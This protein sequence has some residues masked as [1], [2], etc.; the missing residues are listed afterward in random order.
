MAALVRRSG[1]RRTTTG[2]WYKTHQ[3]SATPNYG[4]AIKIPLPLLP[5]AARLN[6][7]GS[8]PALDRTPRRQSVPPKYLLLY[9]G[10]AG[11]CKVLLPAACRQYRLPQSGVPPSSAVRKPTAAATTNRR[12]RVPRPPS[13]SGCSVGGAAT[14]DKRNSAGTPLAARSSESLGLVVILPSFRLAP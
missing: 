6:T 8:K 14:T 10:A 7:V 5:S 12:S 2:A 3:R 1:L 11:P 4:V 13:P 9:P